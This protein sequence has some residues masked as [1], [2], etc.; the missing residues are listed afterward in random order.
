MCEL[1]SQKRQK[2]ASHGPCHRRHDQFHLGFGEL[3]IGEPMAFDKM[4]YCY[5]PFGRET[6]WTCPL[7]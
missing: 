2:Q 1:V 6:N 3:F 7:G 4:T 5:P